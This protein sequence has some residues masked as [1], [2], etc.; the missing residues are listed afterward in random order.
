M[1][2]THKRFFPMGFIKKI[3]CQNPT[4]I[5]RERHNSSTKIYILKKIN[6]SLIAQYYIGKFPI[7]LDTFLTFSTFEGLRFHS[8]LKSALVWGTFNKFPDFFVWALLLIVHT[9]NSSPLPS[10]LLRLLCTGYTVPIT[11]GRPYGSLLVLACQWPS[12]QLLSSP[13]LSYNDS[14]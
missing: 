10:N 1:D 14:L 2:T 5:V 13:Q 11:S 6:F 7:S 12:S 3:L 8:L 4:S 9:W